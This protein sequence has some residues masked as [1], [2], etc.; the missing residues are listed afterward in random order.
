MFLVGG[1]RTPFDPQA[2]LPA[3][4][5]SAGLLPGSEKYLLGPEATRRT[6]AAFP[7][8]L[9]GFSQG[10]EVEAAAYASEK[11]RATLI[12]ISYPTPQIARVR[13]GAMEK[14]LAINHDQGARSLYGKRQGSFVFLVS[15]AASA[16]SATSLIDRFKVSRSLSWDQKPPSKESI[17]VQLAKLVLANLALV[18]ILVCFAVAGGVLVFFSRRLAAKWF[19]SSAWGHPE[20]EL[21]IRLNLS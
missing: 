19:P 17:G 2:S 6:L 15:D 4:L 10:A 16:A 13:F 5:P 7:V 12:A 1:T 21:I 3:A 20:T 8:D 9:I 11:N 18:G 14:F